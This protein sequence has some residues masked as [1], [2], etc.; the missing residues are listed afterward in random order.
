MIKLRDILKEV[1]EASSKPYKY[2]VDYEEDKTIRYK[3]KTDSKIEY[4]INIAQY[5]VTRNKVR[6]I[7]AFKT[8]TGDYD[9]IT[10]KGEHF[11]IMSTVVT[12]V[13]E[14]LSKVPKAVEISFTPSKETE[15][16]ERRA[17]LYKAYIAK[18]LPGSKIEVYSDGRYIV[19]LP[20][21]KA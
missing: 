15:G 4:I 8:K 11:R 20:K 21:I 18:Q 1:G 16:D 19:E 12:A 5:P 2:S 13:K 9:T 3:F 14:Y 6:L 7:V 17:N 10:N